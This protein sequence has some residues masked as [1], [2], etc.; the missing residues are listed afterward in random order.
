MKIIKE[1]SNVKSD[2]KVITDIIKWWGY[3]YSR[4]ESDKSVVFTLKSSKE[5]ATVYKDLKSSRSFKDSWRLDLQGN[6]LFYDF[7]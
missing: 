3:K 5:A 2:L 7:R 4:D 6:E 1:A